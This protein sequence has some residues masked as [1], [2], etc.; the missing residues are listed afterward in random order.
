MK[1]NYKLKWN[2]DDI[3]QFIEESRKCLV[4]NEH[5]ALLFAISSHGD[6]DKVI[7]DSECEMYEL[8]TLFAMYSAQASA[9]LESY[10][11]TPAQ[12][13]HLLRIPKIFFVDSCRG[14][15]KAKVSQIIEKVQQTDHEKE[16]KNVFSAFPT[17]PTSLPP[18]P[19]STSTSAPVPASTAIVDTNATT[20][21]AS[22][23]NN[24]GKN[25]KQESFKLKGI[26]KEDAGK[27]AGQ[28]ANFFKL[29][30]NTE[31]FSV[32]GGSENGGIFLRSVKRVFQDP[33]FVT[34]NDWQKIIHKIREYTKRDATLNS[35][36]FNFTQVVEEEGT[37]ERPIK[38]LKHK[39]SVDEIPEYNAKNLNYFE[40]SQ[41]C[42]KLEKENENLN[43]IIAMLVDGK[44][45]TNMPQLRGGVKG[46]ASNGHGNGNIDDGGS[47]A[48]MSS[49]SRPFGHS[50]GN[51]GYAEYAESIANTALTKYSITTSSVRTEDR[52]LVT[53]VR[54]PQTP[55]GLA[56]IPSSGTAPS[57][58]IPPALNANNENNENDANKTVASFGTHISLGTSSVRTMDQVLVAFPNGPNLGTSNDDEKSE[59]T[60]VF[61]S[62]SQVGVNSPPSGDD[63]VF[64]KMCKVFAWLQ[65][66]FDD[67]SGKAQVF[68][69]VFAR[70]QITCMR[71]VCLLTKQDLLKIP[72]LESSGDL[73]KILEDLPNQM[74]IDYIFNESN[75]NFSNTIAND[76][77]SDEKDSDM[78]SEKNHDSDTRSDSDVDVL[79]QLYRCIAKEFGE[80]DGK[81]S[82]YGENLGLR[83]LLLLKKHKC[84]KKKSFIAGLTSQDLEEIGIDTLRDRKR[85]LKCFKCLC[86]K[87]ND[88]DSN[89]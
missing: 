18:S 40:L 84:T 17:S 88:N 61:G 67:N 30:A 15:Q 89:G 38:F 73:E 49:A 62:F 2:G 79:K 34:K 14:N 1:T 80:E 43:F 51:T 66:L 39:V 46:G 87:E 11:E 31:G 75:T 69:R 65:E 8:D 58:G 37:L 74:S 19:T 53:N 72:C 78:V 24:T 85:L 3:D 47:V 7:Y 35:T 60:E 41:K 48:G 26:N 77:K 12:S 86:T 21:T 36:L 83:Y 28:M 4:L 76:T 57:L 45:V 13:A 56:V 50:A 68:A 64:K 55:N 20:A 22:D 44:D 54:A 10:D 29:F 25:G 32:M 71:D 70:F 16:Q 42:K 81:Y 63:A 27:V 9:L 23:K 59:I 5:D 6:R 33:K 82:E 52:V